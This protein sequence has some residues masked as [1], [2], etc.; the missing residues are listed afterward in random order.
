MTK[1][2]EPT[3]AQQKLRLDDVTLAAKAEIQ[4]EAVR[5]LWLWLCV[6]TRT[7]CNADPDLLTERMK[8]AGIMRDKTTWVR[9]L[10]GQLLRNQNGTERETPLVAVDK[11]IEE[12]TALKDGVRVESMRGRVPFVPTP[13]A[14]AIFGYVDIKRRPER[15][16]KFG[17]IIGPTGS[18]KTATLREYARRNNHGAVVWL[19]A[20]ENGSMQEFMTGLCR[21][22]GGPYR[23]AIDRR[24]QRVFESVNERRTIIVDNCQRLY[25]EN[26]G[27]DQPVFSFL[28][29]LQDQTGCTVI[30]SITPT[31]E[32]TL[33]GSMMAGYFEQFEGRA[34]GR[35]NFLRLPEFAPDEDLLAIAQAFG[36]QDA[37]RALPTLQKISREPGR[38][39]RLFEDLQDA[40]ILA[41]SERKPLT[42]AHLR[43]VREEEE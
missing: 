34:G 2:E 7:E 17:V 40:K 3:E 8:A 27:H 15:V 24:R 21:A 43:A 16:N 4:P 41:E 37:R 22:Y 23:E 25:R 5:D 14:K 42:I 33:V 13:S 26:R 9:I 36:L 39:R 19:E 35:R 1:H 29:R 11:L 38:I 31:F 32:R 20:P 6:Y 18:Q 28:Q 12:I 10:K 30:L